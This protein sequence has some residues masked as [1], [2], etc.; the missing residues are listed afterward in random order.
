L[1]ANIANILLTPTSMRGLIGLA[2]LA[3]SKPPMA[4]R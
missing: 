3:H 1:E 4:L 2:F